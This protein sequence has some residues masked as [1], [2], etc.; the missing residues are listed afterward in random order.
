VVV[1]RPLDNHTELTNSS[2]TAKLQGCP[3]TRIPVKKRTVP[4]IHD[5]QVEVDRPLD[6]HT[7]LTNS[8]RTAKLQGCPATIVPDRRTVKFEPA[9]SGAHKKSE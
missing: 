1:D 6:N 2:S 7:E 5:E 4:T 3:A 9:V 8:S